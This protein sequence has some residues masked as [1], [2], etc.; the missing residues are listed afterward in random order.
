MKITGVKSKVFYEKEQ[1]RVN[2]LVSSVYATHPGPI[3]SISKP[4]SIIDGGTFGIGRY[5]VPKNINDAV[6]LIAQ[7]AGIS[8]LSGRNQRATKA[9]SV[10]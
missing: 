1:T 6:T 4:L 10:Y 9:F 5:V 3:S 8:A 2:A 7:A